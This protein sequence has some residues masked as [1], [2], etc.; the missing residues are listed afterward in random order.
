MEI[1]PQAAELET[2]VT[3]LRREKA[4]LLKALEDAQ[5]ALGEA[6]QAHEA[7]GAEAR[8]TEDREGTGWA[9]GQL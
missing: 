7:L 9:Y 3:A 4:A 6:Q 1:A 2:S 5:A 8:A